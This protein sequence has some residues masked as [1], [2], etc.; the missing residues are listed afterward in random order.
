[1]TSQ[2]TARPET[3]NGHK[4]KKT[5]AETEEKAE[6]F[7]QLD[8]YPKF[9]AMLARLSA[10]FINLSATE[11]DGYIDRGL[12]LLVEYLDIDRSSLAEFSEDGQELLVKHSYTRPGF[13]PFP[14]VNIAPLWPWYTAKIRQGELLRFSRLPDE[15]PPEAVQEREYYRRG[16]LPQSHLAI[17]FKVG[18]SVLG[19]I[20]LGSFRKICDWPDE[21]VQNL[22]LVAEIFANA[23]ARKRAEEKETRLRDQLVLA[24]RVSLMGELAASIAH[25]VNQPLCAIVSNAQT[26]RRM[27]A[28]GGFS[29][30]EVDETLEDIVR[31]GQRASAVIARIR[32]LFNKAPTER[33]AIDLNQLIREVVNLT[34][35][36]M[37]RRCVLVKMDLANK[38]PSVLGDRVEL[39]QVILNL[40][41]NAADAMEHVASDRRE[42]V[43]RSA[44]DDTKSVVVSVKDHGVG[45]DTRNSKRLFDSFFTTKPHG[46]GMGLAICKS[47]TEA[48][49][50][51]IWGSPNPDGGSTF[52][53]ML[54]GIPEGIS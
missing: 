25:E 18:H 47:I 1:M 9:E 28:N 33:T 26:A 51:R 53:F 54:P 46:M 43:I 23:L 49:G 11:V 45:I 22:K 37:N 35:W 30:V 36:E 2:L 3:K 4:R 10:A 16:G 20:G 32:G 14:N 27:L 41:T 7:E 24:S 21:L 13:S 5:T 48:H 39:Q 29:L 50:G 38:L 19:G 34:R 42:L 6:L 8:G 17:P 52:Q 40:M 44:E 12:Q 31:D 15:I